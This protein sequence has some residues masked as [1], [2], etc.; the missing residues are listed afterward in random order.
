MMSF[1]PIYPTFAKIENT[2]YCMQEI[3]L[4]SSNLA[5]C[6]LLFTCSA[7]FSS[8][9]SSTI[10]RLVEDENT[11]VRRTVASGFREVRREGEGGREWGR[12]G[13]G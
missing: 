12:E 7:A 9:L 6:D 5:T 11:K 10:K 8:E 13:V 2:D 1:Y 3:A 4:V